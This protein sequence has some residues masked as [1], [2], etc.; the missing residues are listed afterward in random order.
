[1]IK[2]YTDFVNERIYSPEQDGMLETIKNP[3]FS[4]VVPGNC[5]GNCSFC[6][7][8]NDKACGN[9][10]QNLTE[11]MNSLPEQFYQLS[12]TGGEPTLSPY[13][14]D[15]LESIDSERWS[16]T[17]LTSN[18]TNLKKFI[19]QLEGK[20][21]HVNISRHHYN[22]EINESVFESKTIPSSEELKVLVKE[23]NKIGIDVTYSA[24]LTEH[25]N[26]KDEVKKFIKYAKSHGVDQVFLRKQH[27]TLD[28]SEAE[29]AFEHLPQEHH[30]CPV[31]RNTTQHINES[32][33]VWKASVEE[34]SKELG[35][36]YELVYNQNGTLT[37]DWEQ[38]LVV[39]SHKIKSNSEALLEGCGISSP[40]GC[41][42]SSSPPPPKSSGS[43]G[44]SSYSG[45]GASGGSS[46][47]RKETKAEKEAR[48]RKE[49][50]KDR[51]K[52]VSKVVKKVKKELASDVKIQDDE[53]NFSTDTTAG[54]V[55]I[56]YTIKESVEKENG[57]AIITIDH[58]DGS[59][60]GKKINLSNNKDL[61]RKRFK[62]YDDDDILY[63]SGFFFDD[64]MCDNQDELLSWG[65][66]DSGCT[67]IKV[68]VGR[69]AF[70]EEIS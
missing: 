54:D 16:N 32:K 51:K 33:V 65:M 34:P 2:R 70:E 60:N 31:C 38:E 39:E 9:Y 57:H 46:T 10:I 27:G 58:L 18:G 6:F 48:L 53:I 40:S 11:T 47:T 24:V 20:I 50:L 19:P 26:T 59:N 8:K 14:S 42:A 7:W 12:L 5:N 69:N 1:M 55:D 15:I 49:K 45:C 30:N 37:S 44:G 21:Q 43:C 13:F 36:I 66:S 62:L 29:K 68:A 61:E 63:Y 23:L 17:V 41:G 56:N 25:L 3:N 35:M 22:D 52:K 67:K 4:I 28:P 64:E